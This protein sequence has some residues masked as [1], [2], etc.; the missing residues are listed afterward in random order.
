MCVCAIF[1]SPFLDRNPMHDDGVGDLDLLL[2]G[3]GAPDGGPLD[4]SLVSHLA[5]RADDAV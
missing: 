1:L 4:G 3:C 5:V 2:H